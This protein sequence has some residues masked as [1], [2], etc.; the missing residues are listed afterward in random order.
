MQDERVASGATFVRCLGILAILG[1]ELLRVR[2]RGNPARWLMQGSS[3]LAT[4]GFASLLMLPSV[5]A[6]AG[7]N[8]WL[9]RPPHVALLAL[10]VADLQSL[11]GAS[12][13]QPLETFPITTVFSLGALI[14]SDLRIGK[15]DMGG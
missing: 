6:V 4:W 7:G 14:Q 13:Q 1:S 8:C 3:L 12:T 15:E 9:T 5:S 2:M 11:A 10:L